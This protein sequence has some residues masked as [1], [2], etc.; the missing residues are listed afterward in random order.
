[1]ENNLKLW[2]EMARPPKEALKK[3]T[4]GRLNNMTNISPQWRYKVMTEKFGMIGFGW[5]YTVEKIWTS[6]AAKDEHFAFASILL[7]VKVGDVWSEAIPGE[8]GAMLI[9]NERAG[10]HNSDEAFK[11]AVTDALGTAMAKLGVAADIYLGAFDGSKYTRPEEG[12]GSPIAT[13]EVTPEKGMKSVDEEFKGGASDQADELKKVY[14]QKTLL[15]DGNMVK[16][17]ADQ[18]NG[19]Q[20]KDVVLN[21]SKLDLPEEFTA[22][23]VI[24]KLQESKA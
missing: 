9:S 3:I 12:A 11:M 22:G 5:K 19:K 4:G 15:A 13:K 18:V 16:F 6:P 24:Q 17:I 14:T 21:L 1:M 10:M 2:N 7:Y 23:Q 20:P 8:G